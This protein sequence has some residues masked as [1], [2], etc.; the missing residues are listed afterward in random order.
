M[1]QKLYKSRLIPPYQPGNLKSNL[2]FAKGKSGVYLIYNADQVCVY[3]GYSETQL[4]KTVL[5][6]FQHWKDWRQ[7]RVSYTDRD[8]MKVRII[9]T[10]AI[11]AAKLE[12]AL[13]LTLKPKDNPDKLAYHEL[14]SDDNKLLS[15]YVNTPV[16]TN[17][18]MGD[19]P[20]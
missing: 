10:T 5:R 20:F 1:K 17:V 11:R 18:E 9:I 19:C 4:E 2:G 14:R 8:A 7:K 12:K 15:E 16:S 13:I 3:V 6:H